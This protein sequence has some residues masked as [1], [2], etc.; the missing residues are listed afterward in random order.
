[1]NRSLPLLFLLLSVASCAASPRPN[2]EDAGL[3]TQL[4]D[5]L[6]DVVSNDTTWNDL[7]SK[8]EDSTSDESWI[9][10]ELQPEVEPEVSVP[11][12]LIRLMSFNLRTGLAMD[13]EDAWKN[14]EPIVLNM[15]EAFSPDLIG[16][17][18]GLIFQLMTIA[19]HIP[20]YDWVGIGRNGTDFEE[21][22]A[23]F[24]H[25]ERFELLNTGTFWLSD[26]PD[27]PESQ[28]SENQLCVRIVTW[29]EL[30]D[31][32][33]GRSL[34]VFNTHFDTKDVD[35]IPERSAALLVRKI[36]EIA[37]ENRVMVTGDFNELVGS[38]A[39]QIL[40]GTLVYEGVTGNLL[41]PWTELQI[42]EQGSFHGFTG[43]A[44]SDRK[45]D[46]ILHSQ[47]LVPDSASVIQYAEEGHY[48][49]DHFPVEATLR[50]SVG[51]T[52]DSI[53][54][55][56]SKPLPFPGNLHRMGRFPR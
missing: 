42:P 49:S 20:R 31:R 51:R 44:T 3:E 27:V 13:G 10:T 11:A 7:G 45:I 41:D 30:S 32:E 8:L 26:T 48:P 17:Q 50:G 35:D 21:F 53:V 15:L 55:I 5:E 28:F 56:A 43:I 36:E 38:E 40:T 19:E 18:E 14:R 54:T 1:M 6:D 12:P 4:P 52:L 25:R 9:D 2:V 34:F 16:T 24:Y 23:I 46:W 29:A 47:G 37:G 22:C 33:D 39:W